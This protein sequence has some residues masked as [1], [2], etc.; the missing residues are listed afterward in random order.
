MQVFC[1]RAPCNNDNDDDDVDD[2]DNEVN[3][4]WNGYE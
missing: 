3:K 2:N 1:F 4:K